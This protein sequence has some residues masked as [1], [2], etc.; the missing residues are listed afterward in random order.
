MKKKEI[1]ISKKDLEKKSITITTT[2]NE[3]VQGALEE[4]VN[5]FVADNNKK[6]GKA[7]IAVLVMDKNGAV[8]GMIGGKDY[9]QSQF[10]SRCFYKLI[11][12]KAID[13][14]GIPYR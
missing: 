6:I 7:Q 12:D 1:K 2:L 5:K 13:S 14:L 11:F 4:V 10:K 8:L 9:Q 3:K